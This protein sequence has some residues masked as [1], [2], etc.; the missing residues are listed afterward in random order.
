MLTQGM[1][2]DSFASPMTPIP[3]D[4]LDSTPD[5]RRDLFGDIDGRYLGSAERGPLNEEMWPLLK[6]MIDV[7]RAKTNEASAQI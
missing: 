5:D 4:P 1:K 6:T 7:A 2:G 3:E